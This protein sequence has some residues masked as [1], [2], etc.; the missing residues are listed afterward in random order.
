MINL[1]KGMKKIMDE[2]FT[3][4]IQENIL[5]F[6]WTEID[7]DWVLSNI[8][9]DKRRLNVDLFISSHIILQDKRRMG[10]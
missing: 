6:C 2:K 5:K 9:S 7:W 1:Y 10:E 4:I 3:R 8:L